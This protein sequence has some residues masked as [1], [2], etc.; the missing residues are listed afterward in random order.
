MNSSAANVIGLIG[1]NGA[2]KSTLLKMLN[3]LIKPDRGRITIR[4]RIGALIELGA[5]FNPILTGRENIYVNAS[6]LG[7]SK[8]EIDEKFDSIVEFSEIAE[9]LDTPVQNYS[10]G[11]KV[12][13]GFAVA[14]Q[15]EPDVLL[16]DEV[17]AVGDIG[18]RVKCMNRIHELLDKS[19]VIFVS[20]AMQMVARICTKAIAM[21]KGVSI[22]ATYDIGQAI[23][24]YNSEFRV[25]EHR[26]IGNREIEIKQISING[27]PEGSQPTI[28]FGSRLQI[29]MNLSA[30]T[31]YK[32]ID[33]RL[34]IWNQDQR[35][36]L[37]VLDEN[38]QPFSW[39]NDAASV[40]VLVEM[41]PL[42]LKAG[43]YAITI[44]IYDPMNRSVF[45][46]DNAASFIIGQHRSTGC[47]SI[48][49]ARWSKAPLLETDD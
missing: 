23:D 45:R 21:Q 10:S 48:I 26:V 14:A 44:A 7:F 30:P 15:M 27:E 42:G 5:G 32:T 43:K 31:D 49:A 12:R 37:D 4:G 3:G 47:D 1:H 20:H 25:G 38:Y 34:T 33:V 17:L 9:F 11:M 6:V 40:T 13:L 36:V 41:P 22:C 19:A 28:S 8:Q 46:I 29:S 24:F 39:E 2:G 18:F 35:P 16:I